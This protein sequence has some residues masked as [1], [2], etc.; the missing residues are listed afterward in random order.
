MTAYFSASRHMHDYAQ[1][2]TL[3]DATKKKN[4]ATLQAKTDDKGHLLSMPGHVLFHRRRTA[5][6]GRSIN[7]HRK[8]DNTSGKLLH[9]GAMGIVVG[10]FVPQTMPRLAPL[11]HAAKIA[12]APDAPRYADMKDMPN[13][14]HDH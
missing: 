10:Y 11:R 8:V 3:E 13:M 9:A 7:N 6:R 1:Q 5:G 4:L 14:S 2:I 12:H